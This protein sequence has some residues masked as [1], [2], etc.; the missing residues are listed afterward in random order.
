M[1]IF[2]K[3]QNHLHQC[4][5]HYIGFRYYFMPYYA[6]FMNIYGILCIRIKI[7]GAP[8]FYA[9]TETLPN[10]ALPTLYITPTTSQPTTSKPT[11]TTLVISSAFEGI[12]GGIFE[13]ICGGILK[14]Y[15]KEYLDVYM[16]M[17]IIYG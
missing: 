10:I 17:C 13:S 11:P 14:E 7:C 16:W 3:K 6:G 9:A 4:N 1:G 8:K 2:L 12:F 5:G 15:L